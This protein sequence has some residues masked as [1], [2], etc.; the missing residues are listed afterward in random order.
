MILSIL[1]SS[2][3]PTTLYKLVRSSNSC[4]LLSGDNLLPLRW[5]LPPP[6]SVGLFG[7]TGLLTEQLPRCSASLDKLII[8]L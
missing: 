7:T 1:L 4:V 2:Y 3:S 5:I 8:Y 6:V